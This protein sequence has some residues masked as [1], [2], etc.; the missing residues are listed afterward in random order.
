MFAAI[1]NSRAE[2][3][4]GVTTAWLIPL[5]CYSTVQPTTTVEPTLNTTRT[6]SSKHKPTPNPKLQLFPITN[7]FPLLLPN[8]HIHPLPRLHCIVSHR[9]MPH[10][11][12]DSVKP[13]QAKAIVDVFAIQGHSRAA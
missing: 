5:R 10:P 8:L 13:H 1:T 7:G 6:L 12:T 4:P 9:P 11:D 2:L 3:A